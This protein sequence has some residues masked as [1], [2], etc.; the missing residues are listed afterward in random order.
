MTAIPERVIQYATPF[1]ADD[2][3]TARDLNHV[4]TQVARHRAR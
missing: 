2:L 1:I 4:T 3:E